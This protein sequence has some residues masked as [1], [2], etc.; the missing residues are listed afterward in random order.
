MGKREKEV[1]DGREGE[2][3][4]REGGGGMRGKEDYRSKSHDL[5]KME[6]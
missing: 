3:N 2:G 1:V 4:M 5:Y 6:V